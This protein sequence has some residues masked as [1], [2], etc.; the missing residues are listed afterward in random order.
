MWATAAM[1]DSGDHPRGC[2]EHAIAAFIPQL[3]YGSSPRMRGALSPPTSGI[4]LSIVLHPA[5]WWSWGSSPRMRGAH[6]FM[7]NTVEGSRI[8]P[9]DAGSTQ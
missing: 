1:P 6:E 7:S 3:S 9:A 2:G 5:S 8:I 4:G